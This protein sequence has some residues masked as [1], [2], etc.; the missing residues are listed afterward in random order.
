MTTVIHMNDVTM[1][2]GSNQV[3]RGV[4]LDLH[5]GEVTGLLGANGAGKTT[6]IKIL[7]GANS[8]YS[9]T[10]AIDGAAVTIDSPSTSR[11]LGIEAVHQRISDGIVPGLSVAENLLF[12]GIVVSEVPRFASSRSLVPRAREVAAVLDLD[13]SDAFLRSDAHGLPI[14]D[15]QLLLL[16][17][18]LVRKPRLLVLDEPTSAL[19][20]VE[21]VRLFGVIERLRDSGVAILYVSHR[22]GEIDDIAD[23]LVVLR[24]GV[25]CG[26]HTPPFDWHQALQE[27]LGAAGAESHASTDEMRGS[28]E[29]LKLTGVKLLPKAQTFDVAFRAGEVAGV[30][31]LLGSG[32][33]ELANGIFGSEPFRAGRMTLQGE[34]FAP[35]SPAESIGRHVFMVPED[36]MAGTIIADWSISA[37][38]TFPFLKAVSRFGLLNPRAESAVGKA[39]VEDF[40]VVALSEDDPV[41]S[42]SGG[43]QQKVVI[44]RWLRE[45]PLVMILDEPFQGID[46]G[47]RRD[48]CKRTR[49][50][51]AAGA[52]VI[53]MSSDLEEIMQV[54]DRVLVF[55]DGD[56]RFD[57][58]LSETSRD[59]ILQRLSEVG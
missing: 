57:S 59:E 26:E 46:V 3:L 31:G 47:A 9:G 45:Q 13:W 2:F 48:L 52:A 25:V 49:E 41:V 22:L 7:S 8:N 23:R 14:A 33:S 28:D 50:I 51:A 32:L 27:M 38:A 5:S 30:F 20:E 12:E 36:R 54:A 56:L 21:A 42:L 37:T 34:P 39:V 18:A 44:G 40:G 10:V 19:S 35:R 15:R 6:L 55:V 53:T 16:A 58:Y 11:A 4:E 29:V 17:R 1:S 43:N 24:D